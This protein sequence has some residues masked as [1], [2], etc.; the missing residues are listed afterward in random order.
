MFSTN[1]ILS[2]NLVLCI[3]SCY[4]QHE[5]VKILS[6][7]PA[8][9]FKQSVIEYCYEKPPLDFCSDENIR[10]MFEIEDKRQKMI[11]MIR[12]KNKIINKLF[13]SGRNFVD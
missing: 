2:I 3:L 5:S 10:L 9:N 11:D 13:K 12:M 7:K 6:N 8:I 4:K 1:S